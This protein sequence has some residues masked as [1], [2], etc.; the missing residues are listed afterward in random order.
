MILLFLYGAP[1][2]GKLTVANELEMLTGFKNFHNHVTYDLVSN[3]FDRGSKPFADLVTKIREDIIST[4]AK[5]NIP[6]MIF[7]FVYG[8]GDEGCVEKIIKIVEDNGGT[9]NMILLTASKE[10]LLKRIIEASRNKYAKLK[11][12]TILEDLMLDHD[13]NRP[14]DHKNHLTIDTSEISPEESAKLIIKKF[15]INE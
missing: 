13:F 4:A 14:I 10:I 1:G 9:V 6:G 8:T 2:V 3:Y 15:N 11:D 5:E 12:P 7:T